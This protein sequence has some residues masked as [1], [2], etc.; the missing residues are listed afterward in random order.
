VEGCRELLHCFRER[1]L[2]AKNVE[3]FP[4]LLERRLEVEARFHLGE[5]LTTLNFG[6]RPW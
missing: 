5:E 2:T 6:V 1:S 3:R 4:L